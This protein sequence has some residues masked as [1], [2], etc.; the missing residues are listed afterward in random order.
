MPFAV[1][2]ARSADLGVSGADLARIKERAANGCEVLGLRFSHDS[3]VPDAR[4]DALQRE[5][6]DNF[7]A[8]T[9]D[10]APGNSHGHKKKAHSVLTEDLDN[11]PG[12][13]T[14]TALTQVL[15]FFDTK[16]SS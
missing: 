7:I 2:K 14:Q 5:L 1:G 8:V 15:D 12:T 6:G 9:L 13:P 11:R 3:F 16:L 4:W 10:S